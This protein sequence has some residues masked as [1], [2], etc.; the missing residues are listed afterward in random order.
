MSKVFLKKGEVSLI[1]GGY[2]SGKDES[3]VNNEAFVTAQRSA[4]YV[5]A[6]AAA[7]KGKNFTAKKVDNLDELKATVAASL[8][9][10]S[11]IEYVKGPKAVSKP[12]HKLLE[13]EA[14]AFINFGK[15]T[16]KVDKVN[17]FLSRFNII[18][19]FEEHGLFFDQ[20]IVKM[21]KIYT[22]KQIIDAV[23]EVIDLLD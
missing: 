10:E 20:G 8:A 13:D 12:T 2:L 11:K 6:F 15:E 16:S 18:N 14:L 3:P 22:M 23:T 19:E 17:T 4:E 5:I 9:E 21:N 7:A 1:N